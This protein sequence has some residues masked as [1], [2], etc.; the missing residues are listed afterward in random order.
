[1]LQP[2]QIYTL[3]VGAFTKYPYTPN[4]F[5]VT[6]YRN[7]DLSV[8]P[9]ATLTGKPAPAPGNAAPPRGT[10]FKYVRWRVYMRDPCRSIP[11]WSTDIINGIPRKVYLSLT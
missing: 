9:D 10:R 11:E 7:R 3:T 1:M 4:A 6:G 2:G 8:I 5:N